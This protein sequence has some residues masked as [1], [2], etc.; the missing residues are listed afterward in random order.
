MDHAT[1]VHL[2]EHVGKCDR[3]DKCGHHFTP[4][5]H[6]AAGGELI[7]TEWAP[8]QLPPDLPG[9]RMSRE[10]VRATMSR[11]ASNNL[12]K[13]LG[14]VLDCELVKRTAW[15]YCVGS[16]TAPGKLLGS[17]VFWQV[18]RTGEVRT[19]KLVQYD[20]HTGHRVKGAQHW[21]HA[22]AGGV[23]EGFRLEQCLFGEH[24][25]DKYPDAPVG[26]VEAEKTALIA[27]L[28]VPDVLWIATGGKDELKMSKLLPLAGRNVT[29]WPDLGEGFTNWS[30]KAPDLEP[31][32]ASLKV[33]D[34][35]D[36]LATDKERAEG[37]DLADYLLSGSTHGQAE[38]QPA[39][40]PP[41]APIAEEVKAFFQRHQLDYLREV[42]DLDLSRARIVPWTVEQNGNWSTEPEKNSLKTGT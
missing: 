11:D 27:R 25:L 36:A 28:Y 35:L 37:L 13:Y 18:D 23:P 42:L 7:K 4:S 33:V 41:P 12:L 16:W 10:D 31:L 6:F 3:V 14:T 2:A 20:S 8:P 15:E 29:L 1:G 32:F 34:L 39:R 22:L 19:A 40:K 5:Q 24:L 30:A 21:T 9:Y 38:E 17:A 26:I